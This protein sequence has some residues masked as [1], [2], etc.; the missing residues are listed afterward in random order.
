MMP[1]QLNDY[2][3]IERLQAAV[4]PLHC[5]AEFLDRDTRL[6]LRVYTDAEIVIGLPRLPARSLRQSADF[7]AFADQLRR[8]LAVK[9]FALNPSE[10]APAAAR[11]APVAR[12][13]AETGWR[14]AHRY[15]A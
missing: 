7:A 14:P 9:G 12:P 13:R 8:S 3:I 15:A 4:A 10:P 5:H 6:N 1:A 11:L 2:E